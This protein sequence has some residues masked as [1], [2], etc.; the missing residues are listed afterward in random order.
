M[1]SPSGEIA[2]VVV[3]QIASSAPAGRGIAARTFGIDAPGLLLSTLQTAMPV[4]TIA[5][6]TASRE[7]RCCP[8]SP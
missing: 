5:M 4:A 8:A 1:S 6:R 7:V 3:R 2:T